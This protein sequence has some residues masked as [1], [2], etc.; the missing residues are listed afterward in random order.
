MGNTVTMGTLP[1]GRPGHQV[2]DSNSGFEIAVCAVFSPEALDN[3]EVLGAVPRDNSIARKM[4]SL[5]CWASP[6]SALV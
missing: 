3:Y 4:L 2:K 6:K 1:R 5:R